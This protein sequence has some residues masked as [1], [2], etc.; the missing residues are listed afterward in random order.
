MLLK[1]KKCL[2]CDKKCGK[3]YTTIKYRYEDSMLAEVQ[4]CEECTKLYDVEDIK[5]NDQSL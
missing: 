4:I 2:I 3:I 1:K 5:S